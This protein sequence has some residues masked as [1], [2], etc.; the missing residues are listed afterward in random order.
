MAKVKRSAKG[1]RRSAAAR[2]RSQKARAAKN[3]SIGIIDRVLAMLPFT[4]EQLHKFFLFVI[5]ATAVVV[6]R[7]PRWSSGNGADPYGLCSGG[8]RF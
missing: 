4:D 3:K 8:R 5:L 7:K 6:Y 1:V 2:G